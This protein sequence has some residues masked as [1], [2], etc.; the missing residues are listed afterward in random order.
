MCRLKSKKDKS[1]GILGQTDKNVRVLGTEKNSAMVSLLSF[2]ITK[3]T[4]STCLR[5]V[6]PL[7]YARPHITW[8]LT[9]C[10][11]LRVASLA[12]KRE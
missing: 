4:F 7:D 3:K 6:S 10:R 5:Y 1:L 8:R 9:I 11:M 2:G 12:S